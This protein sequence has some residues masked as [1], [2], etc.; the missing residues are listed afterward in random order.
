LPEVK[1]NGS[2]GLTWS[3]SRFL[4]PGILEMAMSTTSFPRSKTTMSKIP[5]PAQ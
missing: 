4:E 3:F 5:L 2:I 1:G